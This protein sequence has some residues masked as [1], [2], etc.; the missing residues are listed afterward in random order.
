MTI[1]GSLFMVAFLA[2]MGL[3]LSRNPLYGLYGYVAVFYLHPPS[4]WWGEY[5]PDLRWSLLAAAVTLISI[6][7]RNPGN[8][9]Q[10]WYSTTAAKIM[11]AFTAWFWLG[12]LWALN[13]EQHYLTAIMLTK[14]LLVYYMIYRLV[15]TPE[16]ASHFLLVHLLGCFYLG[17]LGMTASVSGRLDGVGGPGIDDSNT[18]GMQAATG[19]IVG[20]V[21]ALHYR[22]WRLALC[23]VAIA[24]T[25][26]IIVL[27]G[28]R[29]AFLA[30][31]A[32][33][34]AVWLF[35]PRA[36]GKK[37]YVFAAL[38]CVL[39][40]AVASNQFWERMN[41]VKAVASEDKS[42]MDLSAESR[43]V[44]AEAQLKMAARFPF[45][46][47]HRGSEVLSKEYL[48]P[49]YMSAGGNARSSHNVFLT[50]LVEQGIPGVLL[51]FALIA[52]VVRASTQVKQDAEKRDDVMAS[53]CVAAIF[54]ALT[55]VAVAGLFADF[56]KCEVQI[57][58]FALLASLQTNVGKTL[59]ASTSAAAV[60]AKSRRLKT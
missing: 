25:L 29:G 38:G 13:P 36:Y 28:S 54:G 51:S 52:W 9:R 41:T 50:V 45:G 17:Y 7:V 34:C 56:A 14:Y 4:R 53:V 35:R 3:S 47:G 60:P 49:I 27:A 19:V 32:G 26:N 6:W 59:P 30:L 39:I 55:V 20:G 46:A 44:M 57:W 23:L 8:V 18:L 11:L 33:G 12:Y 1:T 16:K 37:F 5:L 10:P 21:L 22:T 42:E 40:G 31:V 15:D 48:D 24:L 2:A 58:M 43:L